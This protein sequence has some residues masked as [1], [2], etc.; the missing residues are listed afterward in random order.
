M[1]TLKRKK[2]KHCRKLFIPD[3]RNK[4]HQ[5][6]CSKPECRKASK[7]ASQR[8]WLNKPE[9]R[10]HFCGP[11]NVARVQEWRRNH[12][13]YS[14]KKKTALQDL[15]NLQPTVNT[16]NIS[17]IPAD[18]L[19]DSLSAQYAV[20]IGLIANITGIALQDDIYGTLLRLQQ[21]GLDIL[22]PSTH[23]KGGLHDIKTSPH[24]NKPHPKTAGSVQLDRSQTCTGPPY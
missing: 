13:G 5:I 18:A 3:P 1:V 19:Q 9:N 12:P 23:F 8:R 17:Q 22:N 21:L 14:K 2:C 7:R 20:L 11:I 24:I 4:K 6:Y 16:C 10:D 15:L